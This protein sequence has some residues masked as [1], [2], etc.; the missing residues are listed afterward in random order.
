MS[1]EYATLSKVR[2]DDRGGQRSRE[3]WT[4]CSFDAPPSSDLSP[5]HHP[6]SLSSRHSASVRQLI[7]PLKQNTLKST[8]NI[9]SGPVR[10]PQ[11]QV[12]RLSKDILRTWRYIYV[13]V[14]VCV[15]VCAC[16]CVCLCV[17][18]SQ[19]SL[20][21]TLLNLCGLYKGNM[22]IFMV[23]SRQHL[24]IFHRPVGSSWPPPSR[25][26]L[27]MAESFYRM[28]S[29]LTNDSCVNIMFIQHTMWFTCIPPES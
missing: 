10:F 17:C 21:T 15:C 28:T 19:H 29:Q 12:R 5:I 23:M 27:V 26:E 18:I 6:L 14:C 4:I 11:I 20:F 2:T 3:G 7:S 8:F 1:P 24:C 13:C 25:I 9:W 16:V 22:I